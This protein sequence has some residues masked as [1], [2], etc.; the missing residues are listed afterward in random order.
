MV[1]PLKLDT[2]SAFDDARELPQGLKRPLEDDDDVDDDDDD[3]DE[4]DGE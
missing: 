2:K 1:E 3:L 4:S